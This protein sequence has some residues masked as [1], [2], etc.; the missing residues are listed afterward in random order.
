[1]ADESAFKRSLIVIAGLHVLLVAVFF[2]VS[3]SQ[4][5]EPEKQVIAWIDGSIGGGETAGEPEI[6]TVSVEKP[7]AGPVPE[8]FKPEE[9]PPDVSPPPVEKPMPSELV[10]ATPVPATPKPTTPK[11]TTPKPATPK[12]STPKPATPK[13]ATPKATPATTPK[14]KASPKPAGD[15][16]APPKPKATP[17]DKPKGTPTA[18]KSEGGAGTGTKLAMNSKA[19]GNGVGTGNG[20]GPAKKGDGEG[21]TQYGWYFGMIKDRFD[22]RWEQPTNIERNGTAVVTTLKFRI[23]KDGLISER[24]IAKSSGYPQMDESVLAAAAKVQ[25]VDPL[26]TGLGNGEFFEVNVEFK[27][28]QAQ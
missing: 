6:Q 5:K 26:P 23:S 8:L 21:L 25:Q 12:P 3:G 13:P 19:G 24:E 7:P 17:S 27:L 15:D 10:T 9:V 18:A 16:D 28:E 2:F 22:A 1:M 20:K 4:R 14:P 11:P